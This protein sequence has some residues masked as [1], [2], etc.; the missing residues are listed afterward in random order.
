MEKNY[1]FLSDELIKSDF[2][3]LLFGKKIS[4]EKVTIPEYE[5]L[6]NENDRGY[7]ISK[8]GHT[9]SGILMELSKEQLLLMDMWKQVPRLKREKIYLE[10]IKKEIYIY[11]SID[12][13]GKK[14]KPD[15]S[16]KLQAFLSA[17]KVNAEKYMDGYLMIPCS[18]QS[19]PNFSKN[20]TPNDI[21]EYLIHKILENNK[22]EFRSDFVKCLQRKV[23]G[24]FSVYYQ[25]DGKEYEEQC[26]ATLTIHPETKLGIVILFFPTLVHPSSLLLNKSENMVNKYGN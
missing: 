21:G 17:R 9:I 13:N 5:V 14:E 6:Y 10:S 15:I 1:L 24:Q 12:K 8:K 18:L 11:T 20:E 7:L 22:I 23:I 19:I 16:E 25:S 26:Y 2:L 4:F 3:T